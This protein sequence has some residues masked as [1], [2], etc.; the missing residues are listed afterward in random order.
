MNQRAAVSKVVAYA[1]AL[2]VIAML[3]YHVL[4]PLPIP[5]PL[6]LLCA[7]VA[8][9][10]LEGPRFGAGFG[11]A[12]GL[13]MAS[14]GH[15]DP[16]CL[17]AVTAMGWGAGV[18]T[19]HVLRRDLVGYLLCALAGLLIWE[20]WQVTS[21]LSAGVAG[22]SPLLR[23]AGREMLCSLI[24]AL[25]VYWIGRFCCRYYGRIYHE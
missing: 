17:P 20:L 15:T 18:L 4:G 13:L 3:N 25:P 14:L 6:L 23:T 19:Q 11:L 5:L 22:A 21:R 12:A 7:A 9:G 24:F 2:V 16:V 8:V 10:T 1:V